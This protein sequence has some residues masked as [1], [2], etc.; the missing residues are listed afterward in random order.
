MRLRIKIYYF[1]NIRKYSNIINEFDIKFDKILERTT[2]Y[3]KLK[4]AAFFFWVS[5]NL[6]KFGKASMS[7]WLSGLRLGKL[8]SDTNNENISHEKIIP[9][10]PMLKFLSLVFIMSLLI[11]FSLNCL[12]NLFAKQSPRIQRLKDWLIMTKVC[13]EFK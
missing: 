13:I 4:K 7:F 11:V 9:N 6:E 8:F 3:R 12:K 2:I 10:M 1:D 5:L